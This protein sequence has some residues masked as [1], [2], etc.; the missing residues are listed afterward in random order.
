VRTQH[1]KPA[2]AAGLQAARSRIANAIQLLRANPDAGYTSETVVV[3]S[4]LVGVA[5]LVF[6]SIFWNDVVGLA[7]NVFTDVSHP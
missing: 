6:G 4:L 7:K 1:V 3:T 5:V 2:V